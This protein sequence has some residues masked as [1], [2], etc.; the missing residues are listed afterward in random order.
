MIALDR[1]KLEV[2][3]RLEEANRALDLADSHIKQ[4]IEK[5]KLSLEQEYKRRY[6]R[7]Y[8]QHQYELQQ[9]KNEFHKQQAN[10]SSNSTLQE[11]EEM[12]KLYRT[13]NDRLYR[14]N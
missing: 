10:N 4:E 2:E 7:D 1:E 14:K 9:L 11:I 13:E 8:K 6:E 12:K 3:Q 5:I